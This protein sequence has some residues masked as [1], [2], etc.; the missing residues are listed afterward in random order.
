M[1]GIDAHSTPTA[2]TATLIAATTNP[3]GPAAAGATAEQPS[4]TPT[5]ATPA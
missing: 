2:T 5:R 1:A 4:V 3:H